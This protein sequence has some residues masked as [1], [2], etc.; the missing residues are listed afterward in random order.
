MQMNQP[1]GVKPK[2]REHKLRNHVNW[3]G[4]LKQKAYNKRTYNKT[5][6]YCNKNSVLRVWQGKKRNTTVKEKN[7]IRNRDDKT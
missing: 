4:S 5:V 6:V 7:R 1:N 2:K 3:Q